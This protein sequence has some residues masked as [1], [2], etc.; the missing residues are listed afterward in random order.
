MDERAHRRGTFHGIRKPDIEGDL[1]GFSTG[2]HKEQNGN[3]CHGSPIKFVRIGEDFREIKAPD[4]VFPQT[5]EKEEHTQ[6]ETE[7]PHPVDDKSL[8]PRIGSRILFKPKTDQQ[9][10]AEANTLP[11]DEHQQEIIGQDEID[12]HEDEE[13]EV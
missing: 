5:G 7:V 12:H 1:C 9:I 2:S 6:N 3:G 4:I 10:R 8:L 13:I 11:S